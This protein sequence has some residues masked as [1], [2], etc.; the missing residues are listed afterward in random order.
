MSLN[1]KA[2]L[3]L[4]LLVVAMGLLVFVPAGT[5]RYWQAW[6]WLAVYATASVAVT[7]YLMI[8]DPALLAR[9]MSGGP[10]AERRP[11]QKLIML[12]ASAAFIAILVVPALDHRFGWSRVP[13]TVAILGNVLT[14]LSFVA[15]FLV[16]RENSFTSATIEV[17]AD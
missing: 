5:L 1:S 9:R 6:I 12:L 7:V 8:N 4:V 11:A 17:A 10:I 15:I 2:W 16:F 14:A 13:P 3:S